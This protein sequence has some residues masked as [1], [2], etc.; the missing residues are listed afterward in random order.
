[1]EE[2]GKVERTAALL[3]WQCD[4]E[5]VV[6]LSLGS[7]VGFVS[8]NHLTLKTQL[9]NSFSLLAVQKQGEK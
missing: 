6:H 5:H 2:E 7:K 9:Q 8:Q 4:R 3:V 1:M